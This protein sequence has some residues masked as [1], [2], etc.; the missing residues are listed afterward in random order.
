MLVSKTVT[1]EGD[2]SLQKRCSEALVAA[3]S[4]ALV[5][6][7]MVGYLLWHVGRFSSYRVVPSEILETAPLIGKSGENSN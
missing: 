5:L 4:R 3:R 2:K 1:D 6:I 7:L